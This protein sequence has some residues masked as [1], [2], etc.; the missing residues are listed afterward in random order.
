M[1]YVARFLAVTRQDPN[2]AAS[3][4]RSVAPG[5]PGPRRTDPFLAYP[6][7]KWLDELFE[8][9]LDDSKILMKRGPRIGKRLLAD[10]LMT[11]PA[12]RA[13]QVETAFNRQNMEEF[14]EFAERWSTPTQRVTAMSKINEF[15]E[16]ISRLQDIGAIETNSYISLAM[17]RHEF[18]HF[19][20]NV[21]FSASPR[22]ADVSARPMPT[23]YHLRLKE[24]ITENDFAWPKSLRSEVNGRPLHSIPWQDPKTGRSTEVFCPVLP[25]LLLLMLDLPLRNVQVRRLDSGEGDA[26]RWN[27]AT[28]GWE[29]NTGPHGNYWKR[30]GAGNPRRGC[31]RRIAT[32]EGGSITGLYVNSNKTQ[33]RGVLFDDTAGYEIPWEHVEVLENLAALRD[34]Q[35]RYNPVSG[36]LPHAELAPHIFGD[37]PS[38]AVRALIPDRFYLFRYPQNRG[39]AAPRCL[40]A[41]PHACSSST[42]PWRSSNG[43]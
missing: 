15:F 7:L 35:E 31:I 20:E 36:P 12:G 26:E 13:F 28:R 38:K 43:A 21:D 8:R 4:V 30:L 11:L 1:Q 33:D 14:K 23:R 16:Y 24:I 37:E 42:T 40:S 18:E 29:A 32:S 22:S 10:F 6:H 27:P 5:L 19:I 17:E 34:W 41:M 2:F 9:F 25:R 3:I 39:T